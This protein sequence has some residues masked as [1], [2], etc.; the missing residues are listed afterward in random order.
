MHTH[1]YVYHYFQK[2]KPG[3][4]NVCEKDLYPEQGHGHCTTREKKPTQ[5]N[6]DSLASLHPSAVCVDVCV[7]GVR[8]AQLAPTVGSLH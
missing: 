6:A 7:R 5:G 1:T 2:K 3:D 8:V 4:S